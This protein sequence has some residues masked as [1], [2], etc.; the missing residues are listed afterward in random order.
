VVEHKGALGS[1]RAE[2]RLTRASL[3]TTT[4]VED[5]TIWIERRRRFLSREY[6]PGERVG[7]YSYSYLAHLPNE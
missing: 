3:P 5:G 2:I 4:N 7:R 1:V 6:D